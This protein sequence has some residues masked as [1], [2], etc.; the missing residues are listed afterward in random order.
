MEF[1]M[2]CSG[3]ICTIEVR[4]PICL[5]HRCAVHDIHPDAVGARVAE[6]AAG[7]PGGA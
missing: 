4:R 6:R 7:L 3:R 5:A 2:T 1:G